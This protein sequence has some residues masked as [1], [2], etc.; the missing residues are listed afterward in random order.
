[1]LVVNYFLRARAPAVA[2]ETTAI[3]TAAPTKSAAP[4]SWLAFS[5]DFGCFQEVFFRLF[6]S[7]SSCQQTKKTRHSAGRVLSICH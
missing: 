1:M 7:P 5:G 2:T 6:F 4:V 3:A